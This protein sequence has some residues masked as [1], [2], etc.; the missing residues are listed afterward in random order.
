LIDR[1]DE[2]H[3]FTTK[4]FGF[5]IHPNIKIASPNA[6]IADVGAGSG[7]WLLDVA[8]HSP[9]T[10]Q[11]I[12]Y[13]LTASGFPASEKLPSNV[14][15][16]TH[17]MTATFPA[18]ELGTYDVVAVR[19][20]SSVAERAEWIKSVANLMTLLKPG[21]WLQWI[22]SCNFQIYNS[23]AGTSRA[24]CQEIFDGLEPF[25]QKKEPVI[26][27]MMRES[28][29]VKR[30]ESFQEVGFVEV[31]EDV[32]SSD[33]LQDLPARD[34]MTRNILVCF[35]DCLKSLIGV[36]GSGWTSERIDVLAEKAMQEVDQGAYH[37][38]DQI[39]IV[40]RKP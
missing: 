3:V 23:V 33:R 38:L 22:D 2:Q 26:G 14:A 9:S 21:G 1:L 31:H 16:K 24:A 18:S 36:D 15:F 7:A 8:K 40:G 29:N 30:I 19:F 11:F 28:G 37:T 10:Y 32:F 5:L 12:G 6:K 13:D 17:D 34:T 25:R 27:I 4:T 39:C 20:V 35:I